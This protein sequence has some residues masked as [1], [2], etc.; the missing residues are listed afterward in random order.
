MSDYKISH[1]AVYCA[2]S[3]DIE[4]HYFVSADQLGREMA[5]H[6]WTLVYGGGGT[7]LMGQVAKSIQKHGG[8]TLGITPEV[9]KIDALINTRD[10][11]QI[12]THD[13]PS[14]KNKMIEVADAFIALPGGFGTLEELFEV[15]T[16]KQL[17]LHQKPIVIANFHGYYD[18]LL[19]F[20]EELYKQNFSKE[21][22]RQLYHIAGDAAAIIDYLNHYVP[23]DLDKHWFV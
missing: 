9:L 11:E 16:L 20:F 19:N 23:P 10:D 22:Y 1:V 6:Q 13:M 8:K 12:I 21:T 17:G 14:R 3:R 2:S 15:M 18:K 7:G 4:E 5:A